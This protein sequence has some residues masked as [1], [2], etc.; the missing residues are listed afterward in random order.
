MKHNCI[1]ILLIIILPIVVCAETDFTIPLKH[2]V[3]QE[4]SL[5]SHK[6]PIGTKLSNINFTTLGDNKHRLTDL[7]SKG[8]V[9]F[10][11]LSAECPVAQRYAMRLKRMHTEFSKKQVTIVGVYSN[12]NDSID[13][14]KSYLKKAEYSFPIIKDIDG[15]LAR[16]LRATMTPQAHLIDKSGVLRYRGP[17][18]DNR[19]VTRVKHNYL[20]DAIVAVL[21][22]K[23]VPIKETPAFGCTIHLPD[24]P[25]KKQNTYNIHIQQIIQNTKNIINVIV[26]SLKW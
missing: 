1:T 4:K 20:K 10:V 7:V 6:L 17:I 2:R 8:P 24:I 18:D 9:V 11:F 23:P 13:D 19:Y 14:V 25:I 15:S 22:G 12:E 3:I 26:I 5:Q 16:H 21:N